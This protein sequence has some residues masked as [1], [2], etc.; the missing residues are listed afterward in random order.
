MTGTLCK[1]VG[2]ARRPA[3]SS[4]VSESDPVAA[5]VSIPRTLSTSLGT[6]RSFRPTSHRFGLSAIGCSA[7]GTAAQPAR[8]IDPTAPGEGHRGRYPGGDAVRPSR[9][10]QRLQ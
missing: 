6:R 2:D 1:F 7:Q 5:A 8:S 3:S 9:E 10:E 4:S